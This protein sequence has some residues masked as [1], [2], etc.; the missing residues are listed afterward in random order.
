M[1]TVHR[2]AALSKA[3]STQASAARLREI[4]VR[5]GIRRMECLSSGER[6]PPGGGRAKI[7]PSIPSV[8]PPPRGATEENLEHRAR[9]QGRLW[10]GLRLPPDGVRSGGVLA[11]RDHCFSFAPGTYSACHYDCRA[12]NLTRMLNRRKARMAEGS[13]GLGHLVTPADRLARVFRHPVHLYYN[14]VQMRLIR[15]G[16]DFR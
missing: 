6:R 16:T 7:E 8:L 9:Q 1:S 12:R 4:E 13:G 14:T 10:P 2:I 11:I 5:P 15:R 3:P